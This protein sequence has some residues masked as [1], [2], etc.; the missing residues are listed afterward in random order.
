MEQET[1]STRKNASGNLDSSI[2]VRVTI[3]EKESLREKA[4]SA[5]RTLSD[6]VRGLLIEDLGAEGRVSRERD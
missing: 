5:R 3:A 4:A 2:T 6:H 1:M